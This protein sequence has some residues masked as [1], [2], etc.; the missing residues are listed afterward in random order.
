MSCGHID[1]SIEKYT[2]P[3]EIKR[4]NR[5]HRQLPREREGERIET[6]QSVWGE[7]RKGKMRQMA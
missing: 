2:K 5:V 4:E 6:M 7:G 3:R 1:Q